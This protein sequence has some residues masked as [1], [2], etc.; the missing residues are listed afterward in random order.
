MLYS[1]F[2]KTLTGVAVL[3]VV[4]LGGIGLSGCLGG[5][6]DTDGGPANDSLGT[7]AQPV[8]DGGFGASLTIVLKDDGD[9]VPTAGRETFFVNALDASG[10][11]LAFRRV[12]C[13]SEKGLA[14]LEPSSGGVAFEST[15]P[16]GSMSGV[17]G[18]VTPGSFLLECRLEEGFNLVARKRVHVVGDVPEGFQ[19]YPGAAGGNLGGGSIQDN[20]NT[21]PQLIQV[22]FS[23]QGLGQADQNGPI[24]IEQDLDC[25]RDGNTTTDDIEP[26]TFDEYNVKINNRLTEP[27]SI[28]SITF[29]VDDGQG[30]V[31]TRQLN[32]LVIQAGAEGTIT[33]SFTEVVLGTN[34]KTFAGTGFTVL[35]GTFNVTFTVRGTTA[36]GDSVRLTGSASVTFAG[37]DNCGG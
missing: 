9:T 6:G 12:F 1:K 30:V 33:G 31:S 2:V 5:S 28:D 10:Q 20:P 15:G 11:P 4:G 7:G 36:S 34:I 35:H 24:D 37:V 22:T 23:G 16:D 32:G 29:T 3:G 8:S 25:N 26:Y 18:G 19:G 13:D 27:L 17:L 21:S 14:I